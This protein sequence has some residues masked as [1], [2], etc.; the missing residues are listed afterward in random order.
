M[1]VN[2]K[3][4]LSFCLKEY[5]RESDIISH[6]KNHIR[7]GHMMPCPFVHCDKKY[8]ILSSFTSHISRYHQFRA[9]LPIRFS[10]SNVEPGVLG[11]EIQ[12]CECEGSSI[13]MNGNDISG[14]PSTE[15]LFAMGLRYKYLVPSSTVSRILSDY[16]NLLKRHCQQIEKEFSV[17]LRE[18]NIHAHQIEDI[19]VQLQCINSENL[20]RNYPYSEYAHRKTVLESKEYVSPVP[21]LINITSG[22]LKFFYYVPILST[23]KA[24]FDTAFVKKQFQDGEASILKE[25]NNQY[26]EITDGDVFRTNALFSSEYSI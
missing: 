22:E 3:C 10:D 4:P 20:K 14:G 8:K 19:M 26:S 5:P 16:R 23:L 12:S 2:L 24:L 1:L 21:Y 18:M 13:Q 11:N 25:S 9:A 6:L 15:H 7:D 17:S